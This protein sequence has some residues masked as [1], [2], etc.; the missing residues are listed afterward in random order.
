M[1][2][3]D[4][5]TLEGWEGDSNIFRVQDGAVVGGSLQKP[6]GRGNDFLCTKQ[7]YGD[8]ELRLQFKLLARTRTAV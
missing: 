6:I 4:R 5:Q 2:L 8:F 1:S 3:F 7:E